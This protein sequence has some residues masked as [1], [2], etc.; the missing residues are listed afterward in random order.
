[1]S[2][3]TQEN[4]AYISE[5]GYE[6][7]S[8]FQMIDSIT[9]EIVER[10]FSN[11]EFE[12]DF[13]VQ[14]IPGRPEFYPDPV[15]GYYSV[16]RTAYNHR[17]TGADNLRF[18]AEVVPRTRDFKAWLKNTLLYQYEAIYLNFEAAYLTWE[19]ILIPD[20]QNPQL[21]I[22][23][24]NYLLG[25]YDP[26]DNEIFSQ[27][28]S[29]TQLTLEIPSHLWGIRKSSGGASAHLSDLQGQEIA[30]DGSD[31][32]IAIPYLKL[33][34][35]GDSVSLRLSLRGQLW[36]PGNLELQEV[37]ELEYLYH[38]DGATREERLIPP[39]A[40]VNSSFA[41]LAPGVATP[42]TDRVAGTWSVVEEP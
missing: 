3:V 11:W 15:D 10:N 18:G 38:P 40:T 26:D 24:G 30:I 27:V 2:L 33:Q 5:F 1:M 36:Q 37:G 22:Y 21:N 19:P 34:R 42:V 4:Q 12:E 28:S 20:P 32:A 17:Y 13:S 31:R 8:G 14:L 29:Q 41:A 23:T 39:Q 9:G 7:V 35:E 6:L 16:K 25:I